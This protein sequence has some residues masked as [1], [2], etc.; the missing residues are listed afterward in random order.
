MPLAKKCK[1]VLILV[2]KEGNCRTEVLE[3]LK[4]ELSVFEAL[5][6]RGYVVDTVYLNKKGFWTLSQ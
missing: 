4:C 2:G 1:R 6:E 3:V 5:R